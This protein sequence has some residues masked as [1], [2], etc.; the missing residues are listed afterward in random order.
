MYYSHY[1]IIKYV[2]Y[3]PIIYVINLDIASSSK[4]FNKFDFIHLSNILLV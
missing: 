4:V 2:A 1:R 3:E